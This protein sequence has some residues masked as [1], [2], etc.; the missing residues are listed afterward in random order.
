M[1]TKM[2]KLNEELNGLISPQPGH[3]PDV[4]STAHAL[5]ECGSADVDRAVTSMVRYLRQVPTQSKLSGVYV[6]DTAVRQDEGLRNE[7]EGRIIDGV[8]AMAAT[9]PEDQRETARIVAGWRRDGIFQNLDALQSLLEPVVVAAEAKPQWGW[10][11]Q[12]QQIYR[13]RRDSQPP[14]NPPRQYTP[15]P[16]GAPRSSNSPAN[17]PTLVKT[18]MCRSIAAGIPCKFGDHCSFAHSTL[19]LK[20]KDDYCPQAAPPQ[21]VSPPTDSYPP[22]DADKWQSHLRKTKL[23]KYFVTR[24]GECP[25]GDNCHFAH[26]NHDILPPRQE[27][28][29]TPLYSSSRSDPYGIADR[30]FGPPPGSAAWPSQH[31]QPYHPR[32][33]PHHQPYPPRPPPPQHHLY[34]PR[35]PRPQHHQ[36]RRHHAPAPLPYAAEELPPGYDPPVHQTSLKRAP[37]EPP[38]RPPIPESEDTLP[39]D[40]WPPLEPTDLATQQ[41]QALVKRPK[42]AAG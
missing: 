21:Q 38:L 40:A 5:V 37:P 33:P 10:P 4:R 7:F 15:M 39:R 16:P 19:E 35:P 2:D 1:Q 18:R 6:I 14:Y 41:H 8:S 17:H 28:S 27:P 13:P 30:S 23:C 11:P 32:P 12:Q 36:Q 9:S 25:F 42:L 34:P 26:G 22:S 20:R 24:N 31:H 29:G 3:A